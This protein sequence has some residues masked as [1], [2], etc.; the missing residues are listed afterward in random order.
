[1]KKSCI[2]PLRFRFVTGVSTRRRPLI[3]KRSSPLL[4][5]SGR[6]GSRRD[7]P[8]FGFIAG[9]R[10]VKFRFPEVIPHRVLTTQTRL[11]SFSEAVRRSATT[12]LCF[13]STKQSSVIPSSRPRPAVQ[14]FM[15]Y[16]SNRLTAAFQISRLA[17]SCRPSTAVRV[18]HPTGRNAVVAAVG[19]DSVSDKSRPQPAIHEFALKRTLIGVTVCD[20]EVPDYIAIFLG[21]AFN[22]LLWL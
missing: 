18:L 3:R 13:A 7:R 16:V 10:S 11:S 6:S 22:E 5:S 15:G 19:L 8:P 12:F 20:K 2:R 14:A 17:D 9:K 21:E 1:M 4:T